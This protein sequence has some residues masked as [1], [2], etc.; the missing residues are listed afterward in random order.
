MRKIP[1]WR[2]EITFNYGSANY[3]LWAKVSLWHIFVNKVILDMAI[4][5]HAHSFIYY[6]WLLLS[7][8]GRTE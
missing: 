4:S 3:G 6:L 7:Y 5:G 2:Q 8:H 1:F